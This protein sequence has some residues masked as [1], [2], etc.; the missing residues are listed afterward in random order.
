MFITSVKESST[1]NQIKEKMLIMLVD[2]MYST[3]ATYVRAF[4]QSWSVELKSSRF[5][6]AYWYRLRTWW[7]YKVRSQM[8]FSRNISTSD[9]D[10]LAEAK[11]SLR[12]TDNGHWSNTCLSSCTVPTPQGH[13]LSSRGIL[14]QRPVSTR[15]RCELRR[16]RVVEIRAYSGQRI[17]REYMG[18]RSKLGFT[19]IY[20]D[21]LVEVDVATVALCCWSTGPT[22]DRNSYMYIGMYSTVQK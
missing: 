4:D 9:V 8:F 22:S 17:S 18:C 7:Q 14:A 1:V 12:G 6:I 11:L 21:L 16:M 19:A 5:D 2:T 10:R 3:R 20:C 13:D 15:R